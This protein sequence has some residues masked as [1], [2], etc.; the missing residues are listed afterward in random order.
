MSREHIQSLDHDRKWLI[1]GEDRPTNSKDHG[2]IEGERDTF[3]KNDIHQMK[4]IDCF[5]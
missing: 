5:A 4:K 1:D 2:G 3:C